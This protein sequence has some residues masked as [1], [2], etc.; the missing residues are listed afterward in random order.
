MSKENESLIVGAV[1]GDDN[2][3]LMA[4]LPGIFFGFS[5]VGISKTVAI[6]VNVKLLV[7]MDLDGPWLN[8]IHKWLSRL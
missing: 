6:I 1:L 8:R 3:L 2:R 7:N 4:G 5:L